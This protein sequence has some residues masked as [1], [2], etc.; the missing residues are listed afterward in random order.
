MNKNLNLVEI[1]KDTPKGTKLYSPICGECELDEINYDTS[2]IV[3]PRITVL[4]K[5]FGSVK[6]KALFF[7]NYGVIYNY[8]NGECMLF[9]SKDNRDWS[10][11]KASKNHKHFEPF[12]KILV[13][14]LSN[15]KAYKWKLTIYSHYD[16]EQSLHVTLN[17]FFEDDKIIL[18]KDNEDKLGK[19]VKL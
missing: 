6:N 5:V 7:D 9:P 14:Y 11:F 16:K 18:Y 3:K 15:S 13:P 10:T 2:N 17:G 8:P 19:L 4:Y 12:Q 1:L